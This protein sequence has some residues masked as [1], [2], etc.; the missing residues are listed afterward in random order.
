MSS[1]TRDSVEGRV[2]LDLQN[3]ARREGRPNAE[4]Q[5]LYVLEGFLA[6]LATSPHRDRFVLKGGLV[7]DGQAG[8]SRPHLHSNR[9]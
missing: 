7:L 4:L 1:P 6:R 8:E 5:Q 3:K 2:Y 9:G